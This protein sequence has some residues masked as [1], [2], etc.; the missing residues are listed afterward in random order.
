MPVLVSAVVPVYNDAKRIRHALEALLDQSYPSE[1]LEIIV[2]NNR[3][4]DETQK[5]VGEF[6]RR[7]GGKVTLVHESEIQ[8]SYAARNRGIGAA[9]GEILAFTD[10]DCVPTR[11]WVSAGVSALAGDG[12]SCGGGRIE[13]TFVGGR[14]NV[15]EYFDSGPQAGPADLREE[16]GLRGHRQFL[17]AQEHLRS[18]WPVQ[19]RPCLRRRLRVRAPRH[20]PR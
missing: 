19:R 4:T 5:V 6:E 2:V 18:L 20:R 8:T 12:A 17:R 13:F 10:S 14:P 15:F 16:G 9:R 3:S 1:S 7:N 11:D